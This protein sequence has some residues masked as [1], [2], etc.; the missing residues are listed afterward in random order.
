MVGRARVHRNKLNPEIK[1]SNLEGVKNPR[2]NIGGMG[3][4]A[5][6]LMTGRS[7]KWKTV[8]GCMRRRLFFDPI[9]Q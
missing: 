2:H 7:S 4:I 6:Q 5:I 9:I 3:A 1:G 8:T